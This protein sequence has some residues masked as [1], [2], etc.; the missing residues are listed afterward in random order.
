MPERTNGNKKEEYLNQEQ[1]K[2]QQWLEN[3]RRKWSQI[4]DNVFR[5]KA[6]AWT[7]VFT[8]VLTWSSVKLMQLQ[9]TYVDTT[10][11]S[12]RAFIS[13]EPTLPIPAGK[14]LDDKSYKVVSILVP[15]GW[16]NSGTTPTKIAVSYE[17]FYQSIPDLASSFD[18]KDLRT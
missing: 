8:A 12:Q 7:G 6:A 14:A 2:G 16:T 5:G 1:G 3:L 10:V 18:F 15:L 9:Q 13:F 11:A 17:K 4:W